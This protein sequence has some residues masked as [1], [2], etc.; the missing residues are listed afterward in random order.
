MTRRPLAAETYARI[1]QVRALEP[2]LLARIR[3]HA[4]EQL[5]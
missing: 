5:I 4:R 3:R 2:G 1:A